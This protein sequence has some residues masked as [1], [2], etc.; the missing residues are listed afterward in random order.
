MKSCKVILTSE[1]SHTKVILTSE[2]VTSQS[3]SNNL[4]EDI[5][6]ELPS[7]VLQGTS[8]VFLTSDLLE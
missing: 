4:L 1:C 6:S 3:H 5:P 8:K 7:L 2:V